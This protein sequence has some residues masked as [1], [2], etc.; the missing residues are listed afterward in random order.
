[1]ARTVYGVSVILAPVSRLLSLS[2]RSGELAAISE[3]V[4]MLIPWFPRNRELVKTQ[5]SVSAQYGRW[6]HGAQV[7][8]SGPT[9]SSIATEHARESCCFKADLDGHPHCSPC[10]RL[11]AFS[12]GVSR[13]PAR[14]CIVRY[15]IR[16]IRHTRDIMVAESISVLVAAGSVRTVVL[17]HAWTDSSVRRRSWDIVIR[18]WQ[19]IRVILS[20]ATSTERLQ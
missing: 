11:G 10:G 5:Y 9:L 13:E 1:M 8:G 20:E 16:L 7:E 19:K 12:P 17:S 2:S 3:V 15:S 4:M 18:L 14:A 6:V